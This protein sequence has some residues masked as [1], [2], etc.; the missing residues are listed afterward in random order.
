MEEIN[1]ATVIQRENNFSE[2]IDSCFF[3][4]LKLKPD[5]EELGE[6]FFTLLRD[7][8]TSFVKSMAKSCDNSVL[9][10]NTEKIVS[11][12]D[13]YARVYFVLNRDEKALLMLRSALYDLIRGY[14]YENKKYDNVAVNLYENI[15]RLIVV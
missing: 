12:V 6:V 7:A 13:K 1:A 9:E 15:R 14:D 11:L 8:T 10:E 2:K 3:E 5:Q 4:F